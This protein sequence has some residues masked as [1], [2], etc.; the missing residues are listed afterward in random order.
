M[1]FENLIVA[2]RMLKYILDHPNCTIPEIRDSLGIKHSNP[3]SYEEKYL[4]R[5]LTYLNNSELIIKMD[6]TSIAPRGAHYYIKATY[7]GSQIISKFEDVFLTVPIDFILE[8]SSTKMENAIAE[9][10]I[11]TEFSKIT[12]EVLNGLL[13]RVLD[14]LPLDSRRFLHSKRAKL[15]IIIGK[16]HTRLQET[17][18]KI[19]ESL[20]Q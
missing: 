4:Y 1:K 5:A 6:S 9:D 17:M 2:T 3:P 8:R 10:D 20:N 14:E 7:K 11:S 16:Y 13:Q 12:Y 15:S 19:I 18:T